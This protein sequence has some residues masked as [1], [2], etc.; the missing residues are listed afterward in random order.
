MSQSSLVLDFLAKA[1]KE[2]TFIVGISLKAPKGVLVKMSH[3]KLI[4][5][6]IE[7][8]YG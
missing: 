7:D 6:R 2:M 1:I 8:L 3:P 5:N 4:K